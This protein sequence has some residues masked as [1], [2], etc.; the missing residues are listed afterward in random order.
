MLI[1]STYIE[2]ERVVYNFIRLA[3]V[4]GSGADRTRSE[5]HKMFNDRYTS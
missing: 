5:F 2:N 3:A 1:I 4:V